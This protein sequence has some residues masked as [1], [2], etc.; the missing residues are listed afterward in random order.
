M[1]LPLSSKILVVDDDNSL[2]R[3]LAVGLTGSGFTVEEALNGEGALEA[4]Q[5]HS[6][7]V[8]LLDMNMPGLSGIETCQQIRS[9]VPGTGIIML[10]VRDA[11]EDQVLALEAGADDYVTKPFRFGELKARLGAIGRRMRTGISRDPG[12]LQAGA[13]RMDFNQRSLW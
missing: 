6:Y 12:V 8:V 9:C 4:V 3:A 10:T 11:E 5:R 7:D 13:L 2:R 1:T